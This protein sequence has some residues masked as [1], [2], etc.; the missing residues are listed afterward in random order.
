MTTYVTNEIVDRLYRLAPHLR[1]EWSNV[2]LRED[3]DSSMILA[4]GRTLE[5]VGYRRDSG[6]LRTQKE[7]VEFAEALLRSYWKKSAR[8]DQVRHSV[9]KEC[10]DV[11][12]SMDDVRELRGSRTLYESVGD[13]LLGG[14]TGRELAHFLEGEGWR[15]EQSWAMVWWLIGRPWDDVAFLLEDRFEVTL[16]TETVRQW[17]K[18]FAA[19][20]PKVRDFFEGKSEISA[21][22]QLGT[23]TISRRKLSASTNAQGRGEVRTQSRIHSFPR[24]G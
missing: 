13:D 8:R 4:V 11:E 12:L 15:R 10:G 7:Q 22:N 14:E 24:K 20:L 21:S 9:K 18:K 23:V 1:A 3:F 5:K 2:P 19:T 17:Q 6:S 16:P